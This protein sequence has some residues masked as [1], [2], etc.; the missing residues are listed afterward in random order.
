MSSAQQV[1]STAT[2]RD[3]DGRVQEIRGTVIVVELSTRGPPVVSAASLFPLVVGPHDADGITRL[4]IEGR[5]ARLGV[6][7]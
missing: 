3:P 7:P 4:R 5:P 6:P 1:R 2:A